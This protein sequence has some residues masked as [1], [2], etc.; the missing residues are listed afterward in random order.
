MQ[1]VFHKTYHR[2]YKLYEFWAQTSYNY[3]NNYGSY[4]HMVIYQENV[5]GVYTE[6]WIKELFEGNNWKDSNH[7]NSLKLF[8][9]VWLDNDKKQFR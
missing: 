9:R 2:K 5:Q 4:G 7:I 6:N 3:A 8:W 1:R